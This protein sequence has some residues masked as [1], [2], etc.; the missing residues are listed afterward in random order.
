[1]EVL[2][3]TLFAAVAG[4][5]MLV[6]VAMP[7][8]PVL[9]PLAIGAALVTAGGCWAVWPWVV[10]T[11]QIDALIANAL[12][13]PDEDWRDDGS[14]ER[15][16]WDSRHLRGLSP[17][18]AW[19]TAPDE[20][21]FVA[22]DTAEISIPVPPAAEQTVVYDTGLFDLRLRRPKGKRRAGTR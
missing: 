18:N 7:T 5:V 2:M 16:S 3:R 13:D 8:A 14:G 4:T 11:S 12:D 17:H 9:W 6:G 22:A 1:M 21:G 20:R 10:G 19:I 15:P